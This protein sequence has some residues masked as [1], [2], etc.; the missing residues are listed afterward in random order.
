MEG[1]IL[2][3]LKRNYNFSSNIRY[4]ILS[5]KFTSTAQTITESLR[6]AL[7]SFFFW[8]KEKPSSFF[9]VEKTL[10]PIQLL[11]SNPNSFRPILRCNLPFSYLCMR[12]QYLF[13]I[14]LRIVSLLRILSNKVLLL[15]YQKKV[16]LLR[17][18]KLFSVPNTPLYETLPYYSKKQKTLPLA[19]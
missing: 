13:R 5:G 17:I 1:V 16:V 8:V 2:T 18:C 3:N 6:K 9:L 19:L 4:V 11:S 12:C 15:I 14:I 10:C 7:Q